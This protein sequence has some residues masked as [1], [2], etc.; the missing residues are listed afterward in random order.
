MRVWS[1]YFV[2]GAASLFAQSS[3]QTATVAGRDVNGNSVAG[4]SY[5]SA[6]GKGYSER[7]EYSSNIN[8][9]RA[10]REAVEE[11]VVSKTGDTTV[12]E[13]TV[14]R[15]D[16]NG[17]PGP[18]EK[19]RIEETRRADGS[20][21]RSTTTYRSDIN[22]TLRLAEQSNSETRVSGTIADT[23]TV[24]QRPTIN[25]S[26]EPVERLN[27]TRRKTAPNSTQEETVTYRRDQNGQFIPAAKEVRERVDNNGQVTENTTMYENRTGSLQIAGQSVSRTLTGPDG[28]QTTVTDVYSTTVPGQA[29][30][31]FRGQAQL[32]EEQVTERR[33]NSDGTVTEATTSR[34]PNP[35]DPQQFESSQK[36]R[37]VVCK[38]D[39]N[40]R[41]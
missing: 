1:V 10:P 36:I 41:P 9:G 33:K 12:I 16:A 15:Y 29:A 31:T 25:G 5:A 13:R 26:L 35:R 34:R 7:T 32:R 19:T 39:C 28:S 17:N 24:V 30:D 3:S 2:F 38:G 27:D 18:A 11:R 23:S 4:P 20:G 37:E 14:R 22:G 40:P 8:G 21:T 6:T